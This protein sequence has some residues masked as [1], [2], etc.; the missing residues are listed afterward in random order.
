M[1]WSQELPQSLLRHFV[2]LV[3]SGYIS[4]FVSSDLRPCKEFMESQEAP[5]GQ[6]YHLW[7]NPSRYVESL[8]SLLFSA[9]VVVGVFLTQLLERGSCQDTS[10][11]SCGLYVASFHLSQSFRIT[12]SPLLLPHWEQGG[13]IYL[14]L[15]LTLGMAS[16]L[17]LTNEMVG[18]TG[19]VHAWD[20]LMGLTL[21]FCAYGISTRRVSKVSTSSWASKNLY[22]ARTE[23]H[24]QPDVKPAWSRTT[25]WDI[26][27]GLAL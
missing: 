4:R 1:A 19:P 6:D 20:L 13:R 15:P 12:L 27:H 21:S 26:G 25:Q 18:S 11:G 2:P 14:F 9:V 23:P 24:P 10:P 5:H 16:R 8:N 17:Y 7:L 22:G 3:A